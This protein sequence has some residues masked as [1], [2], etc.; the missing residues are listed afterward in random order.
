MDLVGVCS[1]T[2]ENG[3]PRR[4]A[5]HRLDKWRHRPIPGRAPAQAGDRSV[6]WG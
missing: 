5:Q 2:V 3:P 4:T 6:F 1:G